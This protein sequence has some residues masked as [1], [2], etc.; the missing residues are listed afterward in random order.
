MGW[1]H[2]LTRKLSTQSASHLKTLTR[3]RPV[4]NSSVDKVTGYGIVHR[5]S[6]PGRSTDFSLR[7]YCDG[8]GCGAHPA[9]SARA[10][11]F[12]RIAT[13]C[14]IRLPHSFRQFE[15]KFRVSAFKYTRAAAASPSPQITNRA[16]YHI[17]KKGLTDTL[18]GTSVE[19][20]V[21]CSPSQCLKADH[22]I[23]HLHF[24]Y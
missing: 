20:V 4:L 11:I 15:V 22:K 14:F 8:S 16:G 12:S 21:R 1:K 23:F 19:A 5:G 13:S 6:I 18:E 3:R 10:S 2:R 9:P 24:S 17:C 7:H